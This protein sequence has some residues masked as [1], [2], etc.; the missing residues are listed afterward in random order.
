MNASLPVPHSH[1]VVTEFDGGESV[2]VDLNTKRYYQLNETA[3]LI[4]RAMTDGRSKDDIVGSL[5]SVYD[6]TAEDAAKSVDQVVEH[7]KAHRLVAAS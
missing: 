5:T 4:W 1:I 2:L 7:L 3:T 6:V